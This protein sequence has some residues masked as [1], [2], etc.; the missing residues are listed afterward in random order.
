MS[1]N[2]LQYRSKEVQQDNLVNPFNYKQQGQTKIKPMILNRSTS[3]FKKMQRD[4]TSLSPLRE[5]Q[6]HITQKYIQK[7]R[8]ESDNL[9]KK[10]SF[11]QS[12]Y[13]K[14]I[15]KQQIEK[16]NTLDSM[17][18]RNSIYG[19]SDKQFY[20]RSGMRATSQD[21]KQTVRKNRFNGGQQNDSNRNRREYSNNSKNSNY[22]YKNSGIPQKKDSFYNTQLGHERWR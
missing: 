14:I 18:M 8:Q 4:V 9:I 17:M 3:D 13:N 1:K 2:F 11:N 10:Y 19:Q 6:R 22:S 5:Q 20:N 21:F 7:M 12:R 16:M 15:D